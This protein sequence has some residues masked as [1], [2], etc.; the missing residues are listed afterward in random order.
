MKWFD[1]IAPSKP[2]VVLAHGEDDQRA[3]LAR[4]IQRR[5]RLRS[6][7]PKMGEVIEL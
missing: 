1:V 3:A 6:K 2:R 4:L 7:Q 5:Y